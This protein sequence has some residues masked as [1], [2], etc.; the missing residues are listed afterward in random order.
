MGLRESGAIVR[1]L[2]DPDLRDAQRILFSPS[3]DCSPVGGGRLALQPRCDEPG[4]CDS[5]VGALSEIRLRGESHDH[6]LKSSGIGTQVAE[7]LGRYATQ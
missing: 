6:G 5:L 1:V 7:D 4:R 3:P 2:W